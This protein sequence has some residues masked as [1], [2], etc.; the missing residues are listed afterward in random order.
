M[1]KYLRKIFIKI[2]IKDTLMQISKFAKIFVLTW[3]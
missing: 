1:K 2:V 3:K